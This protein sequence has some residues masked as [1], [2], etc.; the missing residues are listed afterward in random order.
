MLYAWL[1]HPV[2]PEILALVESEV[3]RQKV[4][5]HRAFVDDFKR[6]LDT[7]AAD[8][9]DADWEVLANNVLKITFPSANVE[10]EFWALRG[11]AG[12]PPPE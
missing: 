11:R 5:I 12:T 2:P 1:L 6:D 4:V 8:Q 7:D 3:E 9:V 10:R